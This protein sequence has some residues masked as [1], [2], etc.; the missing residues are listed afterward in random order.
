MRPTEWEMGGSFQ[1]TGQSRGN[2]IEPI[3]NPTSE[4]MISNDHPSK[5]TVPRVVVLT[6]IDGSNQL[7]R[8]NAPRM[9][10]A[11]R[12]INAPAVITDAT[13]REDRPDFTTDCN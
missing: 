1:Q 9:N 13:A 4:Q 7:D 11:N 8:L 2:V 10:A 5:G 12:K 3:V 6:T